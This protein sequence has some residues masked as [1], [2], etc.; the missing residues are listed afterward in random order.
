MYFVFLVMSS[1]L[2]DFHSAWFGEGVKTI[3]EM[4]EMTTN[5]AANS[6]KE[7]WLFI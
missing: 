7:V 4:Q 1:T 2:A 3:C 6:I 5:S